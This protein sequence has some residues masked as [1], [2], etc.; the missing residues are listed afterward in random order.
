MKY[1]NAKDVLPEEV[2]RLVQKYADGTALYIPAKEE[3]KSKWGNKSGARLQYEERNKHIRELYER[4]FS[5][6]EI[7]NRFYLSVD[8]IRKIIKN[9][10]Q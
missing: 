9:P 1:L 10:R 6:E 5:F 2:L 3:A 7:A 4:D 8:S